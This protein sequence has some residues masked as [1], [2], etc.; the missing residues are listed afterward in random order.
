MT[1][2]LP[3]KRMLSNA[4]KKYK[5]RAAFMIWK[6]KIK[7]Y[8]GHRPKNS[9][10]LSILEIGSGAGFLLN[11]LGRWYTDALI[12]G[13]DYNFVNVN[14]V[15]TTWPISKIIQF[16]GQSLPFK[17]ESFDI[18]FSIQVAEHL[19]NPHQFF[20]EARRVLKSG[21]LLIISTP[22][23][24]GIT[25][26]LLKEKWQGVKSDHVSLYYPNKWRNFLASNKL[27]ILEDG[28]TGLTGL[29]YLRIFPLSLVNYLPMIIWGY[30]PWD[31][32]ESYM[33]LS[34][35][36]NKTTDTYNCKEQI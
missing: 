1:E 12:V 33:A 15:K 11:D 34:Q 19:D 3:N 22:N 20:S 27:K 18:M 6:R 28:T 16:D 23:P 17:K 13:G 29:R 32:G 30:F 2:Y 25:A 31:K 9:D 21:G 4:I 36:V 10:S 35:K 14:Y 26:K 7:K 24:I 8:D 5:K